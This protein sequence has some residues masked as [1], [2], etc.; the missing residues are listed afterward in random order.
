MRI[1][2]KM[3]RTFLACCVIVYHLIKRHLQA[4]LSDCDQ[5]NITYVYTYSKTYE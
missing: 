1:S 3:A 4:Q 5:I 2:D